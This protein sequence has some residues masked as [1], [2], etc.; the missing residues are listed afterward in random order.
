[1]NDID[2]PAFRRLDLNLLV[3]FDALLREGGVS[4]AAARLCIGQP[5]MSHALARLRELFADDILYREGAGMQPTARALALAPRIR[6][7]LAEAQAVTSSAADFDPAR[8][9]GDFR[10]AL[11]DP[12]EALL[13]PGLVA[14]IRER[15]PGLSL[16][17]RPIPASRQLEHLD[18]GNINLAVGHFPDVREVHEAQLLFRAGFCCVFNPALLDMPSPIGLADLVRHPHIHTSYTGDVPGLT[19]RLLGDAGLQRHVVAQ[20]ASPLAIPF[21]V[22]QSPLLAVVPDLVARLFA[23]HADLAIEPL[24]VDGLALPISRVTHR[25]DRGDPLTGFVADQVA[26]AAAALFGETAAGNL[27]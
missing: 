24:A 15:A 11:N 26:Q 17:V 5:A 3:A 9:I 4:R 22:K 27:R 6:R 2:Y 8:A 16:S 13:L 7:L 1:M 20:A 12:L 25:R 21:V 23:A 18:A 19:D 10:L 14:R